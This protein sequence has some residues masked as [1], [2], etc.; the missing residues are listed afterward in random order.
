M[1]QP[2]TASFVLGA[3]LTAALAAWRRRLP[4]RRRIAP[5]P[6][7]ATLRC[8]RPLDLGGN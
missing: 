8:V 3:L 2:F 1:L 4:R 6:P 5:L 7:G